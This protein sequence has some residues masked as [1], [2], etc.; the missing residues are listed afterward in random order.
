MSFTGFN[1]LLFFNKII[2]ILTK[3]QF[4]TIINLYYLFEF[5]LS[6]NKIKQLIID[7]HLSE[8]ANIFKFKK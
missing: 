4:F 3:Y 1:S 8:D 5:H 2:I 7:F 6:T